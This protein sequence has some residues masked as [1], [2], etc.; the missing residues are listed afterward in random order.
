MCYNVGMELTQREIDLVMD[1]GTTSGQE[2]FQKLL[3]QSPLT[4][5]Q[6]AE[7]IGVNQATVSHWMSLRSKPELSNLIPLGIVLGVHPLELKNMLMTY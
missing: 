6:I 3:R 7:K 1:S 4:Q 5:K 2:T